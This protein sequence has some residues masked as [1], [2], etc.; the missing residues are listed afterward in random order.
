MPRGS[1]PSRD[2]DARRGRYDDPVSLR[3]VIA[4]PEPFFA[5]ALGSALEATGRIEVAGTTTEERDAERL[6]GAESP[7][8]VIAE[9][10]LAPGSGLALTRRIGERVPVVI[11][12]RERVGDVLLDAVEAGARGC[13]GHDL[14]VADLAALVERA[15]TGSFAIDPDRLHEALK[16]IASSRNQRSGAPAQL[17]ALTS[18]EREVLRLLAK[19]L[20]NET[21]GRQ[22]HLSAHTVRTH[23]G[24]LLR[25]LGA[26]SRA[27]AARMAIATG[28]AQP[29]VHVSR[30]RGPELKRP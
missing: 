8:V 11:L 16:R 3:V 5:D 29:G 22:L 25:K 19:G 2:R 9:I 14:G 7:A 13:A 15:S 30:I 27:E 20:D 23:V 28:D 21:I 4:D 10:S 24:K 12:T 26:H 6:A 18:R 1:G 17:A